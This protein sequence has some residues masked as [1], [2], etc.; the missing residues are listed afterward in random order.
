MTSCKLSSCLE[1]L[2]LPTRFEL[3]SEIIKMRQLHCLSP[4]RR[5][6]RPKHRHHTKLSYWCTYHL[7]Q[8][9][10]QWISQPDRHVLIR[11][12]L[13]YT[14]K[15]VYYDVKLSEHIHCVQVHQAESV[16]NCPTNYLCAHNDWRLVMYSVDEALITHMYVLDVCW[17]AWR[18]V[19]HQTQIKK[20]AP[21]LKAC[22]LHGYLMHNLLSDCCVCRVKAIQVIWSRPFILLRLH[23]FQHCDNYRAMCRILICSVSQ[24][25]TRNLRRIQL[26]GFSIFSIFNLTRHTRVHTF[27]HTTCCPHTI[28]IVKAFQCAQRRG[29]SSP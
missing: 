8:T 26:F 11:R 9:D 14:L 10:L 23:V 29:G 25:R 13:R 19:I 2:I 21:R 15:I 12:W 16:L 28:R 20:Q 5:W 18:F 24:K 3:R 17:W 6:H 1:K 22:M 27:V 4:S 7:S